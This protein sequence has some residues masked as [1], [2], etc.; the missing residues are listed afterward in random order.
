MIL[1]PDAPT[2]ECG[3]CPFRAPD[4]NFGDPEGDELCTRPD[5]LPVQSVRGGKRLDACKRSEIEASRLRNA[6]NAMWDL[7]H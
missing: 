2:D 1:V 7:V 6:I 5:I 3:A 4:W